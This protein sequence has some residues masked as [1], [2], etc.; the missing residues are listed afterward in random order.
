MRPVPNAEQPFAWPRAHWGYDPQ[1]RPGPLGTNVPKPQGTKEEWGPRGWRWLHVTAIGYP[2]RPTPG[3][4]RAA[5]ERISGFVGHI[6]CPEC[7]GHAAR[8]VR[9]RPLA[10]ENSDSLQ[11]WAW[12]FHN[13]V[14]AR[15]GKPL[16]SFDAY[17]AA[18]ARELCWASGDPAACGAAGLPG[19]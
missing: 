13:A 15:L 4:A 1:A 19:R 12:R 3:E 9:R 6:P 18:Y 11:V 16:V 8:Y 7:R 2:L 14:N 10:L 5:A 17:R